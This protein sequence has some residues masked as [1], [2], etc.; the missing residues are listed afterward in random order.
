MAS[1]HSPLINQLIQLYPNRID[2]HQAIKNHY[3]N[4]SV[5]N[6]IDINILSKEDWIGIAVQY[7]ENCGWDQNVMEPLLRK[8]A[9]YWDWQHISINDKIPIEF[10]VYNSD[11][12]WDN[13]ALSKRLYTPNLMIKSSRAK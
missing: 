12:P 8:Y 4:P 6:V 11:L 10:I 9:D 3:I 13:K 2:Y 5:L 7:N 1:K